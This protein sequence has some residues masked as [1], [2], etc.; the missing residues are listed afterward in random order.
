MG[1]CVYSGAGADFCDH[2]SVLLSLL[3]T[4]ARSRFS[5]SGMLKT[6]L[7]FSVSERFR[8]TFIIYKGYC[9][10]MRFVVSQFMVK[11]HLLYNAFCLITDKQC[12]RPPPARGPPSH[13]K[14]S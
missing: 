4:A 5:I 12:P 2:S 9:P 11:L 1:V 7:F 10:V 6:R 8:S 13:T 3:R 14:V